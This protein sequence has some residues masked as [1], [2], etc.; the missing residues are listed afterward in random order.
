MADSRPIGLFDSGV[1]GLSILQKIK[2]TLPHESF[3]FLADQANVPY[4][5]K[6][7]SELNQL[8]ERITK[9]LLK[10]DIKMLVVAC[11]TASCYSI[12]YLRSNFKFPI[13]G[14]VPAIKPA[15]NISK[16]GK[17]SIMATPATAKSAYLKNLIKK[18]SKKDKKVLSLGCEG[19]ED[20]VEK[21]NYKKINSL[22]DKYL[23]IINDAG[24]DV[25][26]LGCTHFPF[27]KKDIR[28]R[29]NSKV[30]I[31]DSGEAIARRVRY[32]LK[33]SA[34]FGISNQKDK[35]FTTASPRK[36]SAVASTLLQYKIT[37]SKAII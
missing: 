10:F 9:F 27:L 11:N 17:I 31:I 33:E 12:N 35:F 14:V 18:H 28:L 20:S 13:V 25:I 26:I 8:T 36:F 5:D 3:I 22:L 19:L 24:S 32:L 29:A 34:S 23:K 16:N 15:V 37:S 30:K 4:G 2:R 21:L 6:S 1:G 7:K